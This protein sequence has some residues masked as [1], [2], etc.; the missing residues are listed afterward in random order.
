MGCT[1]CSPLQLALPLKLCRSGKIWNL[2]FQF[3]IDVKWHRQ[4][5]ELPARWGWGN[6]SK[7]RLRSI[8]DFV[9]ISRVRVVS[10]FGLNIVAK[11]VINRNW[12][13]TCTGPCQPILHRPAAKFDHFGEFLITFCEGV[14]WERPKSEEA[15]GFP[16]SAMCNLAQIQSN[17]RQ[18]PARY[19]ILGLTAWAPPSRSK[20]DCG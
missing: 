7:K 19:C 9:K 16:G 11:R 14:T 6:E 20:L 2:G 1:V 18:L 17:V 12:E 4:V 8:V 13:G 10:Y 3:L 5:N 15:V